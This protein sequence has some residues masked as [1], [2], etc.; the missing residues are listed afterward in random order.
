MTDQNKTHG[1]LTD[2]IGNPQDE[3]HDCRIAASQSPV[4][5]ADERAGDIVLPFQDM[6]W[7]HGSTYNAAAVVAYAE[8]YA[9][10][11]V[12]ADRAARAETWQPIATAP[13]DGTFVLLASPRGR[14]ADGNWGNYK[15]WSWPYVMVEPT[16]WM[17][18]PDAPTQ[19]R[20]ADDDGG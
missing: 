12:L 11:A 4:A 2:A 8:K 13:K 3:A 9:R 18:L 16:H 15:V 7:M 14:I 20:G 10:A 17:P 19:E 6:K 1:E 5:P